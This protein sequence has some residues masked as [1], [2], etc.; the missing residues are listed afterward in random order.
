M[1]EVKTESDIQQFLQNS[2]AYAYVLWILVSS[3]GEAYALRN[4]PR[5]SLEEIK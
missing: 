5:E 1:W 4:N 3:S 2:H